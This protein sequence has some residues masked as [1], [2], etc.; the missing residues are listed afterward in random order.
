MIKNNWLIDNLKLNFILDEKLLIK[1][2]LISDIF[3]FDVSSIGQENK[4]N[5][6][7]EL[8][9]DE[10]DNILYKIQYEENRNLFSFILCEKKLDHKSDL[11][12]NKD[13]IESIFRKVCDYLSGKFSKSSISL[14]VYLQDEIINKSTLYEIFEKNEFNFLL[15]NDLESFEIQLSSI[16]KIEDISCRNLKSFLFFDGKKVGDKISI[17]KLGK[18]QVV[19]FKQNVVFED[20]SSTKMVKVF[21]YISNQIL[22]M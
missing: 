19:F 5:E 9:L 16:K 13:E 14:S 20:S 12:F 8:F 18:D 1:E 6:L 15:D 21:N 11:L 10:K 2:S 22:N 4:E 3:S 7:I 17:K